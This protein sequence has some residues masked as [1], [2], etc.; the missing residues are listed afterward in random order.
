MWGDGGQREAMAKSALVRS[1]AMEHCST[2]ACT[3]WPSVPSCRLMPSGKGAH[4]EHWPP[5]GYCHSPQC[6]SLCLQNGP[7][8]ALTF[9]ASHPRC[10]RHVRSGHLLIGIARCTINQCDP[11]AI[12]DLLTPFAWQPHQMATAAVHVCRNTTAL[13]HMFACVRLPSVKELQNV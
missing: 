6:H 2:R 10:C 3:T 8:V 11:F 12:N 5:V 9:F 7:L 13:V 1:W 4:K